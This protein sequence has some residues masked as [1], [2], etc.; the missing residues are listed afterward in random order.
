MDLYIKTFEEFSNDHK[1]YDGS[2]KCF[3]GWCNKP[4]YYEGGDYRFRCSVCEEHAHLKGRYE[5]YL[6]GLRLHILTRM[7]WDKDDLTLAP[8]YETVKKL[9]D[10][11]RN[12]NA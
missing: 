5:E 2:E 11:R 6:R 8:L 4:A 7:K 1:V 12:E 3:I 10:E 9:I